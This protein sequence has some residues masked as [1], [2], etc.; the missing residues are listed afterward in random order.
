MAAFLGVPSARLSLVVRRRT[1]LSLVVARSL[2]NVLLIA[3]GY[4]FAWTTSYI[5]IMLSRGDGLGFQ[6]YFEYLASAW[7]FRGGVLP[8]FTWLL[9]IV[10]FIVLVFVWV[11]EGRR[12]S[13]HDRSAA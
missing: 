8:T 11:I 3:I 4:G 10:I 13:K 12:D 5:V 6:F 2:K 7:T 1:R 9:S